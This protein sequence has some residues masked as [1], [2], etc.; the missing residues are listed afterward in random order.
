M[1]K[2]IADF[3][4]TWQRIPGIPWMWMK[5]GNWRY[6]EPSPERIKEMIRAVID[7]SKRE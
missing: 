7:K 3:D 2:D 5:R 1:N 6:Q 4:L